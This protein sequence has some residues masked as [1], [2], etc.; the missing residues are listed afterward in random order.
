MVVATLDITEMKFSA[1]RTDIEAALQEQKQIALGG[2]YDVMAGEIDDMPYI[3]SL[4]KD[5][6]D[7]L[8]KFH[9]LNCTGKWNDV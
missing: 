2:K 3:D 1:L 6:L 8:M 4:Q 9:A 5:I 7:A